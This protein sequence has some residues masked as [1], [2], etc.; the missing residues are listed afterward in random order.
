MLRYRSYVQIYSRV[1]LLMNF[2]LIFY[3]LPFDHEAFYHFDHCVCSS[4]QLVSCSSRGVFMHPWTLNHSQL[5][6]RARIRMLWSVVII[7]FRL[8]ISVP[9]STR[10]QLRQIVYPA[11]PARKYQAAPIWWAAARWWTLLA[12]ELMDLA[13]ED[14]AIPLLSKGFTRLGIVRTLVWQ[15]RS[16]FPLCWGSTL[17]V[18][19]ALANGEWIFLINQAEANR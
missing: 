14:T 8:Q 6:H 12:S 10:S 15:M 13:M 18:T 16:F 4:C 2:S 11:M 1:V 19:Q 17:I 7:Y 3:L 9:T 5:N